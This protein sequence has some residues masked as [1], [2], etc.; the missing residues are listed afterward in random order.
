MG[1]DRN[2]IINLQ[3]RD[4]IE[5]FDYVLKQS[6]RIKVVKNIMYVACLAFVILSTMLLFSNRIDVTEVIAVD[7]MSFI[8][9]VIATLFNYHKQKEYRFIINSC[10][11]D[12]EFYDYYQNNDKYK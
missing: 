6:F 10:L 12:D 2:K 7:I 4:K 3:L 9:M 5:I 8:I 11:E 1:V